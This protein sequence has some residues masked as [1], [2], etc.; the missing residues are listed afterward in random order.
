MMVFDQNSGNLV[1]SVTSVKGRTDQG[2]KIH[3][4][5]MVD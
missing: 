4:Q 1:R 2:G 5:I 3:F